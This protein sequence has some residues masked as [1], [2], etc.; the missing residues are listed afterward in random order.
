M[1]AVTVATDGPE[2]HADWRIVVTRAPQLAVTS[3]RYR[4]GVAAAG[5]AHQARRAGE[6]PS[7]RILDGSAHRA[8]TPPGEARLLVVDAERQAAGD[9][10]GVWAQSRQRTLPWQGPCR[11]A[12]IVRRGSHRQRRPPPRA[13]RT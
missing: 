2:R 13:R 11:F 3:W 6:G 1:T 12:H 7:D 5:E 10:E 9:L 4:R 8:R